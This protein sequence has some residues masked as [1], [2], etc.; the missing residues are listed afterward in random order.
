METRVAYAAVGVFVITLV[1][2]LIGLGLWLGADVETR[3]YKPYLFITG[4]SAS[5][6]SPGSVVKYR[7]VE[8]GRV[9]S[10]R[11]ENAE[12]VR[13]GLNI[14]KGTPVKTDTRASI[15]TQG[16]TGLA[17]I[18]LIGGSN[19]A[20]DLKPWPGDEPPLIPPAPSLLKRLDVAVSKNL[21]NLDQIAA[22]VKDL[23]NDDNRAALST[24][25]RN[26][27]LLTDT[28]VQERGRVD[29]IM[30]NSARLTGAGAVAF[31]QLPDTLRE[32]DATLREVKSAAA[33]FRE[34]SKV[35]GETAKTTGKALGEMRSSL[36]PGMD[37]LL[38][39]LDATAGVVEDLT[40]KIKRDPSQLLRGP[41]AA[42]PGP[43][44]SGAP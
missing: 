6:I 35:L 9:S 19:E 10:L 8:I 43:G 24:V 40:R 42:L 3:Q 32:L 37:A 23:L 44:E 25:T 30:T 13:I 1:A 38:R 18:E 33:N 27:A 16:V 36:E 11:L 39:Q 31:E 4:E 26:L 17:F 34:T 15:A 2:T 5:G 28:L 20:P 21:E 22:Q 14:E 7:G 12:Q 29:E 41:S